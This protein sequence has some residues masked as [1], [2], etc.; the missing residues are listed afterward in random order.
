MAQFILHRN[1]DSFG[2]G[3]AAPVLRHGA[4]AGREVDNRKIGASGI[5]PANEVFDFALDIP[6]PISFAPSFGT[7]LH[8]ASSVVLGRNLGIGVTRKDRPAEAGLLLTYSS[9]GT[10]TPLTVTSLVKLKLIF[11][12]GTPSRAFA[13]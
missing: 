2:D 3:R 10:R 6:V 9:S 13:V 7:C 12:P 11:V 4:N 5:F 1:V 8:G